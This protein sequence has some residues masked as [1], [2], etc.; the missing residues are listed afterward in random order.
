M[1]PV[2]DSTATLTSSAD[3]S[4]LD[5]SPQFHSDHSL[6]EHEHDTAESPSFKSRTLERVSKAFAP[7]VPIVRRRSRE[8]RPRR[9]RTSSQSTV[10]SGDEGR[11][12]IA[13]E[14]A[15]PTSARTGHGVKDVFRKLSVVTRRSRNASLE[16]INLSNDA[17]PNKS[18]HEDSDQETSHNTLL[19]PIISFSAKRNRELHRLFPSLPDSETHIDD[20]SCALQKE[21]LIHGRL[22]LT[23]RH[24]CFSANIFGYVTELVLNVEDVVGVEKKSVLIIPNAVSVTL[25]DGKVRNQ[26][27]QGNRCKQCA[28]STFFRIA[29]LFCFLRKERR[30]IP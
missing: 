30:S 18:S 2:T 14:A 24:L 29:I 5:T 20:Y 16:S 13:S 6:S 28:E 7:Y 15:E 3:P 1:N 27:D 19:I 25:K 22:Y 21:I 11:L 12:R 10:S 4:G 23:E 8:K 26:D 9:E 17:A